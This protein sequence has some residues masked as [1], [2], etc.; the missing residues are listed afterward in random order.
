[1]KSLM[2]IGGTAKNVDTRKD[3]IFWVGQKAKSEDVIQFLEKAIREDSNQ[4]VR[5]NAMT[6]LVHAHRNLGVP[7]LINLAK[8]H[9]DSEIRRE[10]IF[11][12]G[13]SKDPRAT[14][15]LVEIVNDMK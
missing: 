1:M 2:K 6:A 9:P 13:Q 15:A 10:A 5:K 12:L 3:A 14:E 11:W 8:S 4:E 7:A